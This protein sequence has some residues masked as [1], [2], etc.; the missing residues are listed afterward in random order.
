M[1]FMRLTI[2]LAITASVLATSAFSQA[3]AQRPATKEATVA[4]IPGVVVAAAKW[5]MFW[6]GPDNVD[7]L[8]GTQDGGVIFAQREVNRIRK[9][10][11][12]GTSS[13]LIEDTH[14]A[15]ALGI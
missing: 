13:A 3:P 2:V 10:N 6:S 4:A 11:P 5:Q 14:G 12:D 7:G 1:T 8:V 15:G 9:V